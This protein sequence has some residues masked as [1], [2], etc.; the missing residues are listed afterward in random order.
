MINPNHLNEHSP[1]T[2]NST[3][4]GTYFICGLLAATILMIDLHIPLGV[5]TLYRGHL[6]L[7]KIPWKALYPYRCRDMHSICRDRLHWITPCTGSCSLL[8]SSCQSLL[9]HF[10]HLDDSNT[11]IDTARQNTCITWR[12]I[13]EPADCAR[14]RDWKGKIK[15]PESDHAYRTGHYR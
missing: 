10:R 6:I 8:S 7:A 4:P 2:G 9:G 11:D 3:Q 1:D 14:N 12:T 13:K 15:N 5:A